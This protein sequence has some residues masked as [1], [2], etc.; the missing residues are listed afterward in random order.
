MML[1]G[2]EGYE[3]RSNVEHHSCDI[4]ILEGENSGEKLQAHPS[5]V[6][7]EENHTRITFW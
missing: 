2:G 3:A 6:H 4:V 7:V 1:W 5:N